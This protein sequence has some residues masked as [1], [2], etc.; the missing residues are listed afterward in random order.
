M[1]RTLEI[2]REIYGIELL[3]DPARQRRELH[4]QSRNV[5]LKPTLE[6]LADVKLEGLS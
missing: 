6:H 3:C 1:R 2:L 4:D 5:N